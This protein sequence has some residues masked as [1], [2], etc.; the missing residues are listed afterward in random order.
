MLEG[1]F[2]RLSTSGSYPGR[3]TWPTGVTWFPL[4]CLQG[5]QEGQ[6]AFFGAINSEGNVVPC[7]SGAWADTAVPDSEQRVPSAEPKASFPAAAADPGQTPSWDLK[8][9]CGSREAMGHRMEVAKN[10]PWCRND[11]AGWGMGLWKQM[12]C[13]LLLWKTV[14]T[15]I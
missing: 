13:F 2:H 3:L 9:L 5:A 11:K 1:L 8:G 7:L 10:Q 15:Q 12:S 4:W 6:L 14:I